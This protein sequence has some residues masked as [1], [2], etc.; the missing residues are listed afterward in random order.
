MTPTIEQFMTPA[1][2]TIGA[3]QTLETAME[4]MHVYGVRHLPVR[5]GGKLV[6]IVSERDL[7]KRESA[8]DSRRLYTPVR[9]VMVPA[10]FSVSPETPFAD[11]VRAMSQER[12]GSVLVVHGENVVGIFTTVD[13]A[14]VLADFVENVRG[15]A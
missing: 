7:D 6:G 12:Y 4:M 13:A 8:H 14:R 15:A 9:D 10:P 11:V 1:P 3:D 2:Y 5:D